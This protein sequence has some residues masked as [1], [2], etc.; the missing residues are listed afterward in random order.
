[1]P[2]RFAISLL[3]L[4]SNVVDQSSMSGLEE[5]AISV[6]SIT[7]KLTPAPQRIRS[8]ARRRL[9]RPPW[10]SRSSSGR[11]HSPMA[12][13]G[14]LL[15]D[16]AVYFKAHWCRSRSESLRR[17]ITISAGIAREHTVRNA[18]SNTMATYGLVG[19]P[20]ALLFNAVDYS[21]MAEVLAKLVRPHHMKFK[22][23]ASLQYLSSE[24]NPV[25]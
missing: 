5:A 1:M 15:S 8:V 17:P 23:M 22:P 16:I 4:A 14:L 6:T 25:W 12:P 24:Y 3:A 20:P 7:P 18:H 2:H 11:S 21:S 13:A 10:P 19:T 9:L